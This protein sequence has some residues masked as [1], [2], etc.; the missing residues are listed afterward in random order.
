M[1]AADGSRLLM[2][3]ADGVTG[4]NIATGET[5]FRDDKSPQEVTGIEAGRHG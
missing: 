2:R 3:Y 1:V 5:W 4:F